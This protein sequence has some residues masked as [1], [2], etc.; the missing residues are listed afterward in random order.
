MGQADLWLGVILLGVVAV[1][2]GWALVQPGSY[3]WV[4]RFDAL[5]LPLIATGVVVLLLGVRA[6]VVFWAPLLFLALAWPLPT[7]AAVELTSGPVTRLTSTL[8]ELSLA[9]LPWAP[10]TVREG[11]DLLLHIDGIRGAV[12]VAVTSACSGLSGLL[13]FFLVGMAVLYLFDGRLRSRVAWLVAGLAL[14]L[15]LNAVR[16]LGLVGVASLFGAHLALDVLHPVVGMVVLNVALIVMLL[17]A[18]R[19]GLVRRPDPS[20][21]ERQPAARRRWP[22]AP[23]DPSDPAP[24]GRPRHPD[25][26][27]RCAEPA[28]GAGRADLPERRSIEHPLALRESPGC[29]RARLCDAVRDGAALGPPVLRCGLAL[30]S[31]RAGVPQHRGPDRVGG[32]PRHEL[33]CQSSV[34]TQSCP[35]TG[36][37]SRT[38]A[39]VAPSSWATASWSSRSSSRW[40]AAHGTW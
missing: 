16:I 8:V 4:L 13:G 37:T 38:S 15:L 21:R 12:D 3:L 25:K 31:F 10:E 1:M 34:R 30:E 9:P 2:E 33:A 24:G 7:A 40:R 20:A 17:V 18:G 22:A 35:A 11:S 28:D 19:F 39:R 36:S 6:L 27:A 29:V 23:A 26:P 14:V 32:R 5:A